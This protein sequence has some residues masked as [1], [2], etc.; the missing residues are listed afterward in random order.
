[1]SD[2]RSAFEQL[3]H[4]TQN[5][6]GAHAFRGPLIDVADTM[7]F[8][9]RWFESHGLAHTGADVVAMAALVLEREARSAHSPI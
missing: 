5:D 6:P 9:L 1:M 7:H 3:L 2:K 4:D 8:C